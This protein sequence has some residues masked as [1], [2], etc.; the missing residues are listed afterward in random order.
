[1]LISVLVSRF[2]LDLRAPVLSEVA[3]ACGC[4][5]DVMD[6]EYLRSQCLTILSSPWA[7][8]LAQQPHLDIPGC[9]T[10]HVAPSRQCAR[11]EARKGRGH[12][13][14]GR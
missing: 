14:A 10:S 12:R 11:F 4:W 5:M 3:S 8:L 13:G 6:D 9:R 1:M 2:F 7:H